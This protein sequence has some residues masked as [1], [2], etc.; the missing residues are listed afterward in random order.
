MSCPPDLHPAQCSCWRVTAWWPL[1]F[2]QV[3]LRN[4]LRDAGSLLSTS[5]LLP[6]GDS[7]NAMS[8]PRSKEVGTCL[9]FWSWRSEAG[10]ELTD[11]K[12]DDFW[13]LQR[14]MKGSRE[15]LW[16]SCL[17]TYIC[18][19]VSSANIQSTR[20]SLHQVM[21][22]TEIFKIYNLQPSTNYCLKVTD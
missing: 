14:E 15:T 1:W 17:K 3:S 5:P 12:H 11:T 10:E 13:D 2:S 4:V 18:T 21:L 19:C 22:W 20:G 16:K 9:P 7:C 6:T 8:S